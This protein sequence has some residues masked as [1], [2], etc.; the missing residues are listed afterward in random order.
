MKRA[1][2]IKYS[3]E[4]TDSAT[5]INAVNDVFYVTKKLLSLS[6]TLENRRIR[7]NL[8]LRKNLRKDYWIVF[9]KSDRNPYYVTYFVI[10]GKELGS[11]KEVVSYIR[12]YLGFTPNAEFNEEA[13]MAINGLLSINEPPFFTSNKEHD[14]EMVIFEPV[15]PTTYSFLR[16]EKSES[17][18]EVAVNRDIG[19]INTYVEI[20]TSFKR[21][22]HPISIQIAKE[23]KK[24][25]KLLLNTYLSEPITCRSSHI[26]FET[27]KQANSNEV[28]KYLT[29]IYDMMYSFPLVEKKSSSAYSE[30]ID[31]SALAI[32]NPISQIGE[33][34][35]VMFGEELPIETILKLPIIRVE[36]IP[37]AH[38][39]DIRRNNEE[40]YI[41]VGAD[42]K[43]IDII[44]FPLTSPEDV[45]NYV[46]LVMNPQIVAVLKEYLKKEHIY[47]P[48][49][50]GKFS[51]TPDTRIRFDH[52]FIE[53]VYESGT[54]LFRT[55]IVVPEDEISVT[56]GSNEITI[57][58]T[59][60]LEMKHSLYQEFAKY[61]S[62]EFL[63]EAFQV[64]RRVH[65]FTLSYLTAVNK[66]WR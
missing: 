12:T 39:C 17:G 32:L 22:S 54:E 59:S 61:V 10:D 9:I 14:I 66:D 42:T 7:R 62:I 28:F 20:D 49:K 56:Y 41:I 44:K 33:Y 36:K 50:I 4:L 37:N 65:K 55:H 51:S 40:V 43:V 5:L 23:V 31:S 48:L 60:S 2:H 19:F 45:V 16:I 24:Y 21:L 34:Y 3:V 52:P 26:T 38:I 58:L 6:E 8:R 1:E 47:I 29:E 18:Y 15:P 25:A 57:S 13:N 63:K 30:I 27:S 46:K 53:Y 11:W 35:K 64:L